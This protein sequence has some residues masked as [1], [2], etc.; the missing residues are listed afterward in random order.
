MK[1]DPMNVTLSPSN[2]GNPDS[3]NAFVINTTFSSRHRSLNNKC[4][5][6]ILPFSATFFM[7]FSFDCPIDS[8]LS[9][10]TAASSSPSSPPLDS[11]CSLIFCSNILSIVISPLTS[12][13]DASNSFAP[14]SFASFFIF[15]STPPIGYT[16]SISFL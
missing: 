11:S 9:P 7:N 4:N 5:T 14:K 10:P 12:V 3:W 6:L 15:S 13:F 1:V 2:L 8:S 16:K